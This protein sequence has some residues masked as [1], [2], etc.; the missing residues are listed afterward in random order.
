MAT[1]GDRQK[2]GAF[3]GH[4]IEE[5]VHRR[6]IVR[7]IVLLFVCAGLLALIW[8]GTRMQSVTIVEVT[9]SGGVTLDGAKAREAASSALAG[10]YFFLIPKRFSYTYPHD[11]IVEEVERVPRVASATVE[12]TS[13]TALA[14]TLVEY[15]PYA[16]WCEYRE[17]EQDMSDACLFVSA[18]GFAFAA[19]PSLKGAVLLRYMTE[20]RTSEVGA[21]LVSGKYV[22]ATK[23][24]AHA[25]EQKHGMSVQTITETKD[26]D[27]RYRVRGGGELLVSRDA[28]VQNVFENLDAILTSEEFKHITA[29]NF[30]YIDLRFGEKVFVK[31]HAD[32]PEKAQQATSTPATP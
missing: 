18:D 5:R 27:V 7:R 31:E 32:A 21:I 12:R 22:T 28:D 29:G 26:G 13:R 4:R 10:N 1:W 25:L 8:F 20:E 15:L 2:G 14:I 16:L 9:V 19:A 3:R 6:R 24:F 17:V 23:E 30:L 11:A